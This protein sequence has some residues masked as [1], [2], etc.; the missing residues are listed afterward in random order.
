MF[1]SLALF[2]DVSAGG[3]AYILVCQNHGGVS[4]Q[5]DVAVPWGREFV[6]ELNQYDK[7]VVI[8]PGGIDPNSNL[9]KS[10]GVPGTLM[11][12]MMEYQ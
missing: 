8:Y 1:F 11:V 5:G 10:L 2:G 12:A 9:N 7:F 4:F 3:T 6:F